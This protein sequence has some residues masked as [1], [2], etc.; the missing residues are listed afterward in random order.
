MKESNKNS[1]IKSMIKAV[2]MHIGDVINVVINISPS[3]G[4]LLAFFGI[5]VLFAFLAFLTYKFETISLPFIYGYN[6]EKKQSSLNDL[7]TENLRD[8]YEMQY[9]NILIEGGTYKIEQNVFKQLSK[10]SGKNIYEGV[11]DTTVEIPSFYIGKYEVTEAEYAS[12][13]IEAEYPVVPPYW[14]TKKPKYFL[15]SKKPIVEVSW[16]DANNYCQWLQQ[17][18]QV[19]AVRLPTE[20][21][22]EL[23]ANG[24]DSTYIYPWG[25]EFPDKNKVRFGANQP[26]PVHQL[27]FSSSKLGLF[28]MAGNV[29]EWCSPTAIGRSPICEK[30]EKVVKGGAFNSVPEE[31]KCTARRCL[32]AGHKAKE[33]GF[34]IVLI[35]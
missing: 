23:A 29:E 22:W 2:K 26:I 31:M 32:A 35:E 12:F 19:R 27:N 3:N 30:H 1:V 34:R 33:V 10:A 6:I 7:N 18:L 5:L 21:E 24:N 28:H 11:F 15:N 17:K 14:Q 13:I 8:I 20:I 16:E 4:G 25:T 9:P